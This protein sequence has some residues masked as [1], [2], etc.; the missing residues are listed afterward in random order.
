MP[1]LVQF[2]KVGLA[3][4]PCEMKFID[5]HSYDELQQ[6]LK[7]NPHRYLLLYKGESENSHCAIKNLES[8]PAGETVFLKADVRKVRDIHPNYNITTVPTLLEFENNH[9]KNVVKGCQTPEYYK[10]LLS[11]GYPAGSQAHGE[12]APAKKVKVYSTPTCPWCT[13]L[14]DYLRSHQIPFTDI[15]VSKDTAA[16][17]A[18]VRKSGQQGVPQTEINGRMIIGFDKNKIDSLLDIK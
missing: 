9:L 2:M 3:K 14:K 4:T 7:K 16:A 18:M 8:T 5:I 6:E 1:D 17:Q 10:T 15:D 12:K 13:R 11:Q